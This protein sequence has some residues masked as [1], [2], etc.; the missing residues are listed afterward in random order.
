M[1]AAK[2]LHLVHALGGLPLAGAVSG[3]PVPTRAALAPGAVAL[4]AQPE[5]NDST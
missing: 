1:N 4:R 3:G 5:R 2:A